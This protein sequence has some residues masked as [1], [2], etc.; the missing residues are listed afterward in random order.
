VPRTGSPDTILQMKM[1]WDADAEGLR[2]HWPEVGWTQYKAPWLEN[3][4]VDFQEATAQPDFTKLSPFGGGG[5]FSL[6][7]AK[8]R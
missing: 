7:A 4:S 5:W 8:G 3:E 6:A 1:S 2:C